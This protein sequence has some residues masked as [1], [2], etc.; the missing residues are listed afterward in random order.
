MHPDTFDYRLSP[1]VLIDLFMKES[2]VHVMIPRM[3]MLIHPVG[4]VERSGTST[5]S[6]KDDLSY[7]CLLSP[8]DLGKYMHGMTAME[9]VL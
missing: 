8:Q 5:K 7:S 4:P 2:C 3:N 1:V 9:V 6:A